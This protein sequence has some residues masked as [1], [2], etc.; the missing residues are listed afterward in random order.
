V[1]I[2]QYGAVIKGEHWTPVTAP[3][4]VLRATEKTGERM[5]K[6]AARF[7]HTHEGDIPF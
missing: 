5:L 4:V 6:I 3:P 2:D 1:A 7:G